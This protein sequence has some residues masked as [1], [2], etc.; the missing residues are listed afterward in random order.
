MN[1]LPMNVSILKY[2]PKRLKPY[3]VGC[4]HD[5]DGYW[6]WFSE[7]VFNTRNESSTVHE[8]NIADTRKTLKDCVVTQ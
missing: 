8:D 7:S 2:V 6:I 5:S 1:S 3:V 4:D